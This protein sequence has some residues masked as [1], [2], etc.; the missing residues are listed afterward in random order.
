M[1]RNLFIVSVAAI[2]ILSFAGSEAQARKTFNGVELNGKRLNKRLKVEAKKATK[3]TVAT[4]PAATQGV[5][6]TH[7]IVKL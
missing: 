3:S 4:A 2:S 7:V 5:S 6:L 1:M